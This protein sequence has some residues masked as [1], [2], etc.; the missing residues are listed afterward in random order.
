M[1]LGEADDA[2]VYRLN[3][4]LALIATTDFFTPIVD[5]PY[6]Y[7]SIAAANALSDIYAMGGRPILALNILALP[8]SLPSHIS[9]EIIR[10]G[11]EKTRE[12]G[13]I[14]AGGHSIQDE[15]PKYGLVAIGL[16]DPARLM[17]TG[18]AR[19]G[20]VL[21]LTKPL[22]TGCITTAL[23]NGQT[24]LDDVEAAIDSM[25][26]LNRAAA[27]AATGAGASGA[28]DITG[29]GLLGHA[30]EMATLSH[31]RL[32]F[33]FD[34]IPWLPGA[35]QYGEMI[36]FPGGA[37][38]NRLY[39]TSNVNIAAHLQEYQQ[40]LLWDPQTSGG[41]LLALSPAQL[42]TFQTL[43]AADFWV[44]GQVL[45]GGGIEVV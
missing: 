14:I 25:Q 41:L 5:E 22:G 3:D 36:M 40:M 28:T 31:V 33:R 13:A 16:V 27:E 17:K 39:Y 8:A 35:L 30:V 15:E 43:M 19:P 1:G 42:S 4:G 24:K 45:E 29:F 2:A 32:R 37:F 6:A 20:D 44:V 21:V 11:A 34:A 12:A 18:G 10:G 38:N 7:G 26:R 23:K 9:A